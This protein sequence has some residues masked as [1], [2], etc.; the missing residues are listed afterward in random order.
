[1]AAL[2]FLQ[3]LYRAGGFR[4]SRVAPG[5]ACDLYAAFRLLRAFRGSGIIVLTL[6]ADRN[7]LRARECG[8][9]ML[10]QGDVLLAQVDELP[11][12]MDEVAPERRAGRLEH[13]LAHGE[14]TGHAHAII[15]SDEVALRRDPERRMFLVVEG[16]PS[17]LRHE[18]H[19]PL[20]VPPGKY[21]IV[22][23]RSY[24]VARDRNAWS[25]VRD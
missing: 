3:G 22:R 25:H 6:D 5:P 9:M 19:R 12:G 1:M 17:E 24:D 18:E 14:A 2:A 16:S 7:D 4:L 21:R 8:M 10:R 20:P 13:I 11:S 15:A 23:Q